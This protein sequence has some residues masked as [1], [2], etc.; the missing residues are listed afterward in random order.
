[1]KDAI[2][3]LLGE[4][5]RAGQGSFLAV[6]KT[7]G[8][9]RS[10]G[11]LSFPLE[12]ATL[13]LDFPNRGESTRAL[14]ARLDDIVLEAKGR[15][16]AAKDGRIPKQMWTDGYPDLERFATYVDPAFSSDF[17]RRVVP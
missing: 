5:A 11:L 7:F 13:A 15:L 3:A 4:I 17:W 6:L 2:G 9:L 16:Y 10:P 8:N 14:L 1:M 12:G